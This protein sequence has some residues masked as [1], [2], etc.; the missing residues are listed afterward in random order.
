LKISDG[1]RPGEKYVQL[2]YSLLDKRTPQ[3]RLMARDKGKER[4][5]AIEGEQWA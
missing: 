3:V 2:Q 1:D 5:G 4:L